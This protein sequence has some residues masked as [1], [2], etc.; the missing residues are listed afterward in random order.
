ME[1]VEKEGKLAEELELLQEEHAA[2]IGKYEAT[3]EKIKQQK[4]QLQQLEDEKETL[5]QQLDDATIKLNSIEK[6]YETTTNK[7]QQLKEELDQQREDY[8]ARISNLKKVLKET[9]E[10]F[11]AEH[12]QL[13]EQREA[14]VEIQEELEDEREELE[15]LKREFSIEDA[16][17]YKADAE[18]LE[19][20]LEV[21][22]TTLHKYEKEKMD[23]LDRIQHAEDIKVK[24]DFL[25]EELEKQNDLIKQYRQSKIQW[26]RINQLQENYDD[27]LQQSQLTKVEN[28]RLK[29]ELK[30]LR[31]EATKYR[32]DAERVQTA[33]HRS[34]FYEIRTRNLEREIQRYQKKEQEAI[35]D[36]S[37]VFENFQVLIENHQKT[38]D[39]PAK[40]PGDTS[41][42]QR[43]LD[44]AEQGNYEF[45]TEMIQGF[46]AAMRSTRFIILKGLSG[47]GKT[48]LPK[49]V[50]H[51][52]GGV[53][54][55]IAVQPSWK[56]KTD[57][58]G[59]YNHF[60][61][62]FMATQFTEEL[63]KA[64]LPEN[65]DKFYFIVLDEMNLAR[66]EYYFS[67][68]NSKL[69]LEESK[70]IIE[71]FDTIGRT[72][73]TL[74]E[75]I[76]D[77]NK[78]RIPPNVFFVGTINEDESTYT[79]SDKIY[80]RAQVLDFQSALSNRVG[81]MERIEKMPSV[82]FIQFKDGNEMLQ[83]EEISKM[84]H[85]INEVL[86]VLSKQLFLE[87]GNRPRR[88]MRTFM[89]TYLK[90]KWDATHA[91]DLQ[92]VS[93]IV[94]KI[95]PSY[96][97]EFEITMDEIISIANRNRKNSLTEKAIAK[98]KRNAK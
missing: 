20:R 87:I 94:P 53:C 3:K 39:T 88:H 36:E 37:R 47:T 98:V 52:L 64:Q 89:Q 93:K 6:K 24:N 51:A 45:S 68:F 96:D 46:I 29:A 50:A 62:R 90:N 92:I 80:D 35:A 75:Y 63:F 69:E 16:L 71:L 82:S 66:V 4:E 57:L 58:I 65:R 83:G 33:E 31:E 21:L 13:E 41:I 1:T 12:Q 40:Y 95:M 15:N 81:N 9:E 25:I 44:V 27:I 85:P 79:L 67:D 60:N 76:I 8:E 70:Q 77:G 72:S 54:E 86:S 49:I 78:L 42:I 17:Q 55:T 28:Q 5:V 10:K 91:I 61:D 48:S 23:Y 43:I 32:Q 73:G 18:R 59:F 97:E 34:A 22:K 56:S 7:I 74:S 14:L 38:E 84:M 2:F 26:E 11:E 30:E 19:K